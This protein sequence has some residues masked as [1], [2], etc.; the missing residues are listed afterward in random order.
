[1][2]AFVF[3]DASMDSKIFKKITKE[4]VEKSFNSISVDGCMSTNDTVFFLS[5]GKVSLTNKRGIDLFS[6]KIYKVCLDLAKMIIKDAEGASKFIEI[7]IEGAKTGEEAK[8]AALFI[9][10]SN[11]FKSAIYGADPNWGRIVAAL[12][13]AGIKVNENISISSTSLEKKEIKIIV[14]LKRGKFSWK[15]Y[16][17][18][19]TPEYIKINAAYS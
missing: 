3:T 14:D 15:A 17:S 10:N 19:L 4:T 11:L 1:M 12:G 8:K 9:A 6:E 18:D 16:T 7:T 2:L 5:S 13:Q